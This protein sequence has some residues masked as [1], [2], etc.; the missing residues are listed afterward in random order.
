[1]VFGVD[2]GIDFAIMNYMA[3]KIKTKR[4]AEIE[5]LFNKGYSLSEI[6]QKFGITRE[7]VRVILEQRKEYRKQFRRLSKLKEEQ[8][9]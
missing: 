5:E 2:N 8:G 6:A 4:N 9:F 7:R 1:M 3:N